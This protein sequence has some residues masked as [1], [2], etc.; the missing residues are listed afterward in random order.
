[1]KLYLDTKSSHIMNPKMEEQ[2]TLSNAYSW[3]WSPS[4]SHLPCPEKQY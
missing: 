3:L 2:R 1:L 4:G